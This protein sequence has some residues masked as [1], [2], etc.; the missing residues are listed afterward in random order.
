MR[1]LA[2]YVV[3]FGAI[4]ALLAGCGGSQ[5]PIGAPGVMR[6]TH[7]LGARGKSTNYKVLYRFRGKPDAS[8]PYASLIDVDGTLYGTTEKGGTANRGVIFSI[9][10]NGTEKVL[11]SVKKAPD[12]ALPAAAVIDVKGTLYGTTL[13]GGSYRYSYYS[14]AGTVFSVTTSGAEKVLHSFGHRNDGVQPVASLF[15]GSQRLY[16]TTRIGGK[17]NCGTVFSI[18]TSGSERLRY[19]F[20]GGADGCAPVAGLIDVGGTLY[21]TT[22]RGGAYSVCAGGGGCGTVFS[23][24]K[25]GTEKVLHSFGYGTDGG[26]PRAGLIDVDGTLYGTT[27]SGGTN[28]NG[29]VFSIT[30]SGSEKVVYSFGG[31]TDGSNP[32]AGLI[33]VGGTLYGTTAN[34]GSAGFG[35]VFS[36]STSGAKTVL[37]DFTGGANGANPSA[38]L[39]D[40]AGVLYGTTARGGRHKGDCHTSLGCGTVFAL[41]P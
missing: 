32:T 16:G 6:Q 2:C 25:S 10:Q 28:G 34:G 39:L 26:I 12:G 29:T 8:L 11:Y 22:S 35:T 7:A 36:I 18:T 31:D 27:S 15:D 40:V 9:T 1:T 41:S 5:P 19:S 24:T 21:G 30:T 37:H 4:A 20:A 13:A 3:S 33:D 14:D 38:S 23:V 17:H